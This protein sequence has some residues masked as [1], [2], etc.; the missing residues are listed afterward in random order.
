MLAHNAQVQHIM[1]TRIMLYSPSG[2]IMT[3]FYSKSKRARAGWGRAAAV[4]K[5][6]PIAVV[7][8]RASLVSVVGGSIPDEGVFFA[9]CP[10]NALSGKNAYTGVYCITGV[11]LYNKAYL[12][13]GRGPGASGIPAFFPGVCYQLLS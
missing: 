5:T 7:A 6:L 9:F 11:I 10:K 4:K 3:S 13:L 8:S 2:I 12:A 1:L